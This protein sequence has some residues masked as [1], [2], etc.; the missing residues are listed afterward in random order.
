VTRTI[1]VDTAPAD[2][3]ID[4]NTTLWFEAGTFLRK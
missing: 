4:P 3:V 2:V 1:G